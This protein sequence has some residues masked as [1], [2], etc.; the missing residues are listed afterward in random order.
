MSSSAF[1]F[2]AAVVVDDDDDFG[3]TNHG[4]LFIRR[5]FLLVDKC[6]EAEDRNNDVDDAI[7]R[8]RFMGVIA[9]R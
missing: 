5:R 4:F 8:R 1:V 9:F 6:F 7:D 2:A 3:E